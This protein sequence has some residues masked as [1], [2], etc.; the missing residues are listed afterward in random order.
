[1]GVG[2]QSATGE[3]V[4]TDVPLSTDDPSGGGV[5]PPWYYADTKT[6]DAT[7]SGNDPRCWSLNAVPS[8]DHVF[9][10]LEAIDER[11]VQ[12]AAA[13][14]LR[15]LPERKV[16]AWFQNHAG[17]LR[18]GL[19]QLEYHADAD[20]DWQAN[21]L[22]APSVSEILA[23]QGVVPET[24]RQAGI[25]HTAA[26]GGAQVDLAKLLAEEL[27]GETVS[28]W[29]GRSIN[30][31]Y[32]LQDATSGLPLVPQPDFA[33]KFLMKALAL[34]SQQVHYGPL[35]EEDAAMPDSF[36]I[37]ADESAF[38]SR[39]LARLHAVGYPALLKSV[40]QNYHAVELAKLSG[41]K[42]TEG[43][44]QAAEAAELNA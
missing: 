19:T 11:P 13:F 32:V 3:F 23:W 4:R 37:G 31:G 12:F 27:G 24:K 6:E 42:I 25:G 20:P 5:S 28:K 38:T 15:A 41:F 33:L 2:L 21:V 7:S 10:L 36:G 34:T 26:T 29:A 14:W 8:T 40:L 39:L 18:D 17:E 22:A 1:M 35:Y 30:T 16:L 44:Q 9:R 43:Q